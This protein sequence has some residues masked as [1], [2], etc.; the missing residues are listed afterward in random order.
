MIAALIRAACLAAGAALLLQ[1]SPV[2]AQ[3]LPA[4]RC[5]RRSRANVVA[6]GQDSERIKGGTISAHFARN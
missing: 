4:G 3:P 1:A 5:S 6:I 2:E